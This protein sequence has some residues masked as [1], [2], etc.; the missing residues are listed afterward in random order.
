MFDVSI[1][2]IANWLDERRA[3]PYPDV[4][5]AAHDVGAPDREADAVREQRDPDPDAAQSQ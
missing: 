2:S 1:D 4:G 5:G 3:S